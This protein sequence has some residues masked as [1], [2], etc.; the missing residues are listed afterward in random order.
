VIVNGV[1]MWEDL[2]CVFTYFPLYSCFHSIVRA[3]ST[4]IT[5]LEDPVSL[6]VGA[7][8]DEIRTNMMECIWQVIDASVPPEMGKKCRL[9]I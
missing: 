9:Y 7:Q 6:A 1:C 8:F 4:Y 2:L 3:I 5:D